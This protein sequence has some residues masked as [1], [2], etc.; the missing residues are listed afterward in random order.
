M[1]L[2]DG[3]REYHTSTL[4]SSRA[5]STNWHSAAAIIG[6]PEWALI[7]KNLLPSVSMY[8]TRCAGA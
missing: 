5:V 6:D 3:T 4:E 1:L 8:S 7:R 2:G